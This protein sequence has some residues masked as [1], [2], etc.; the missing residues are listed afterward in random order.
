MSTAMNMAATTRLMLLRLPVPLVEFRA[1]RVEVT[2]LAQMQLDT[3]AASV[4]ETR[5][6][7]DDACDAVLVAYAT[8]CAARNESHSP[9]ATAMMDETL[10]RLIDAAGD[11]LGALQADAEHSKKEA[12]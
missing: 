9:E 2:R 1:G 8:V 7:L 4:R 6:N 5:P 3:L 10:S 12:A 11:M